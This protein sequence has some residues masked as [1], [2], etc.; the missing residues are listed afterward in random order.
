MAETIATNV[1][2][3][4]RVQSPLLSDAGAEQKDEIGDGS[5]LTPVS[6]KETLCAGHQVRNGWLA[7]R[8]RLGGSPWSRSEVTSVPGRRL[9]ARPA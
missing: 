3:R 4:R 2:E 6:W 7:V 8:P 9:T 1:P 5:V